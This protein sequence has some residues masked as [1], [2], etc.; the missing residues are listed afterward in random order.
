VFGSMGTP[1]LLGKVT[2]GVALAFALTSFWLA[3]QG[4]RVPAPILPA[5]PP[6]APAASTTPGPAPAPAPK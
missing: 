6:A 2:T 3:I 5:A 1:S 4:H